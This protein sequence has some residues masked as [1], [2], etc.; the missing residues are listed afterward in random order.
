MPQ[1]TSIITTAIWHET[2]VAANARLG[3][4]V[5]IHGYDVFGQ[6]VKEASLVDMLHLLMTGEAPTPRSAQML[7]RLAIA[8]ANPGPRDPSV[9]AA[10]CGGIGGSTAAACLM[11]ALAGGAG[12]H[13]G[14]REVYDC[15]QLWEAHAEDLAGWA[16]AAGPRGVDGVWPASTHAA[17]FDPV[18]TEASPIVQQTLAALVELYGEGTGT[19]LHWLHQNREALEAQTGAGVSMPFV[20]ALAFVHLKLSP[21]MG[22]MAFL[23]LRLPGAAA[24]AHEQSLKKYTEFPFPAIELIEKGAQ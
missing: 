10:M 20:A 5:R 15:M 6:V 17:G 2:P 1:S 18:S 7:N 19:P 12:R 11:A 3:A 22:E 21:E 23:L 24:H 8:L 4:E 16:T 14:A 13:G 9:Y